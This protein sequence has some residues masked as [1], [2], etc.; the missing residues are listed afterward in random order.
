MHFTPVRLLSKTPDP[1]QSMRKTSGKSQ[2]DIQQNT[3]AVP[4]KTTKI[5]ENKDNLS[6]CH[7]QEEPQ[8]IWCPDVTWCPEWGP[9]TEK[10]QVR[11]EETGTKNGALLT[12]AYNIGSS[13]VTRVLFPCDTLT[14]KGRWAWGV[15]G[16]CVSPWLSSVNLKLFYK[17]MLINIQVI[18]YRFKEMIVD[19]NA[20]KHRRTC[21]AFIHLK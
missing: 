10:G 4:L 1:C 20:R 11:T 8:E 17:Y 5:I 15:R 19:G 6:T 3:W 14:I 18:C 7:S 12:A 16:H 9:G 2:R 13:L 21:K